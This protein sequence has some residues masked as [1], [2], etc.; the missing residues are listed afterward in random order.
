MAFAGREKSFVPGNKYCREVDSGHNA[1][2]LAVGFAMKP[3]ALT[4][5]K[6]KK[7]GRISFMRNRRASNEFFCATL[8]C[9]FSSNHHQVLSLVE[10]RR[11][12]NDPRNPRHVPENGVFEEECC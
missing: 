10:P 8:G 4:H 11:A 2:A 9:N 6:M 5:Y 12:V 7:G 3:N 1:L